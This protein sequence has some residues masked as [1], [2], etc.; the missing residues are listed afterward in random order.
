MSGEN[1][2][3]GE[4]ALRKM[5]ASLDVQRKAMEL[6]A[7][8]IFLELTS[9]PSEGVEPMGIDTPLVDKEGYPRADIDVYRARTQRNRFRVLKTDHKE[10]EGKIEG[11]LLQLASFKD[12]SRKKAES[13]EKA[14]RLAPKPQ[15]KYDAATGKWVVKNWDGSVAGVAGGDRLRFENLS[16]NREIPDGTD[17]NTSTPIS[18]ARNSSRSSLP[19]ASG[20]ESRLTVSSPPCPFA[21]VDGIA[22]ESPAEEAGLQV[23]DLVTQFGSLHAK[24]HERLR[25]LAKFVPEVAGEGGTIQLVVLRQLGDSERQNTDYDDETKWEKLKLSLRPRPFSGRGL[26]GCHILPFE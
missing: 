19:T 20:D 18:P 5:L 14:R 13:E 26:L 24:N 3:D 10:I 21:K 7:D 6:E 23:G 22:K 2:G 11:F 9:P 4:A 12:P 17:T 15:P 1:V 25:A 16:P 8:A